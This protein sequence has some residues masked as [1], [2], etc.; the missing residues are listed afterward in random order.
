MC[1]AGGAPRDE[2]CAVAVER[3]RDRRDVATAELVAERLPRVPDERAD[4]GAVR[5]GLADEPRR[6]DRTVGGDRELGCGARVA[7]GRRSPRSTPARRTTARS[8]RVRVTGEVLHRTGERDLER[9][10]A[11]RI[12]CER[13]RERARRLECDAVPA[14][15]YRRGFAVTVIAT[16]ASSSG[17][18]NVTRIGACT[19][20][21]MRRRRCHACE[22]RRGHV[23][24]TSESSPQAA[25]TTSAL[26]RRRVRMAGK[27]RKRRARDSARQKA[28]SRLRA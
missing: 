9:T 17:S 16:L 24:G 1:P 6:V 25:T 20:T 14:P 3:E 10:D 8:A 28:L 22:R 4:H 18:S 27:H 5:A 11:A 13:D 2:G 19:H 21:G 26:N 7:P 15:R 23:A 12:R